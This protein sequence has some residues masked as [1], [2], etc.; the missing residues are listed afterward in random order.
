MTKMMIGARTP[1]SV[2]INDEIVEFK[3]VNMEDFRDP[4]VNHGRASS[5]K[6]EDLIVV[7]DNN[8]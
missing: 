6:G 4:H 1:L 5:E 7:E 3:T 2:K 8:P